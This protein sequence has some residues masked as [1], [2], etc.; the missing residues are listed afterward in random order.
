MGPT[1]PMGGRKLS[2]FLG[3]VH[4]SLSNER[5]SSY[6]CFLSRLLV[7][8]CCSKSIPVQSTKYGVLC[9]DAYCRVPPTKYSKQADMRDLYLHS[10]PLLRTLYR[11]AIGPSISRINWTNRQETSWGECNYTHWSECNYWK[12]RTSPFTSNMEYGAVLSLHISPPHYLKV[13][14]CNFQ[15]P[16]VY[17]RL[18]PGN[19]LNRPKR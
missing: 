15:S 9:I 4:S 11:N 8:V 13:Q 19:K 17:S 5:W 7:R 16:A 14:P 1:G 2:C 3:I 12:P 10:I 18:D 6:L